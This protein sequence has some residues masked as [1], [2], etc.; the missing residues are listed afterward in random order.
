MDQSATSLSATPQA[1]TAEGKGATAGSAGERKLTR[2]Q[3]FRAVTIH[4]RQLRNAPYNPR[5]MDKHA[6]KRL[7]ETLRKNGLVETPVWNKQTGHI[8]GG[9]QRIEQLD[10][11]EGSDDYCLTVAM[12]DVPLKKEKAINLALNNS[13]IQGNWDQDMLGQIV[14]EEGFEIEATG[15]ERVDLEFLFDRGV[16]DSIFGVQAEAEAPVIQDLE[17]IRDVGAE[18]DKAQKQQNQQEQ[19]RKEAETGSGGSAAGGSAADAS[20]A[21]DAE[22]ELMKD[23]REAY[24]EKSRDANDAEFMAV[25]V[26]DSSEQLSKFLVALGLPADMRYHSGAQVAAAMGIEL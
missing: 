16:V 21:K 17:A 10:T 13:G 9:H 6:K 19:A 4:R 1:T 7:R 8:V 15:F 5:V 20:D 14:S 18:A 23:R 3:R 22:I 2:Y 11:L 12:I 24:I 26:F 25:L